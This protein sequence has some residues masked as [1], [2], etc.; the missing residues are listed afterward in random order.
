MDVNTL[1]VLA[2]VA[3]FATFVGIWW[4]AYARGNRD[5]FDEAGRIPFE[6]D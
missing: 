2:T 1:R 5:R 6:Q 4:W 3:S